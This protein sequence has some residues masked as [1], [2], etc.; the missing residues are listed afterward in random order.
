MT[1]LRALR[2]AILDIWEES[3]LVIG[4]ALL[5]TL[6]SLLILP[7]PFVLAAHYGTAERVRDERAVTWRTWFD[8]GRHNLRFFYPWFILVAIVA[9]ILVTN[10]LF[11][12]RFEGWWA[13]ILQGITAGLLLLWILPQP[14]V[15]AFY[16]RQADR[17]LRVA[18]RNAF[19][20]TLADPLAPITLWVIALALALAIAYV[21]L[22]FVLMVPLLAAFLAT[23]IVG[24]RIK[25]AAPQG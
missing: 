11:Y 25:P 2:L 4:I 12:L 22:P 6:L 14:L 19:V 17:R 15:P 7:V 10:L 3:T 21:A 13:T 8:A 20:V 5:G 18:L 16:Y 24:L 9:V 1:A 23:R